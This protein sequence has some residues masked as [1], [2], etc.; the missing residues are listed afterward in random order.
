[1]L[2]SFHVE[3]WSV[4]NVTARSLTSQAKRKRSNTK[5]GNNTKRRVNRIHAAK[6]R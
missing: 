5:R 6:G 3:S 4:S 1:M 2:L